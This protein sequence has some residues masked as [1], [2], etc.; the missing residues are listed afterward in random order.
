V[1]LVS[2][3][4]PASGNEQVYLSKN[5]Q[6]AESVPAWPSP[7]SVAAA[8]SS[9]IPEF[10]ML[11][12]EPEV[13]LIMQADETLNAVSII[14]RSNATSPN[15]AAPRA[16]VQG[17]R[18]PERRNYRPGVG[19]MLLNARGDVF[20]GRRLDTADAWQM[21]QGGI[22][23]G[24][25]PRQAAFRELKEEIGTEDAII[26]AESKKWFHYDVP[27]GLASK[28]WN[29]R[30]RGQRQKWFVML[31]KA[32]EKEIDLAT[33]HPEFDAWKWVSLQELASLA[34]PFKRQLYLKFAM[35][36]RD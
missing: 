28:A 29:G 2:S 1:A 4:E 35:I 24:E 7:G 5:K 33:G 17:K 12:A 23:R 32:Q 10:I 6:A 11:L 19:I 16:Q 8:D 20:V 15:P 9:N 3:S 22:E 34:A 36:F 18:R 13:R 31:L 26:I 30:W 21:P 27:E 25:T 14:L